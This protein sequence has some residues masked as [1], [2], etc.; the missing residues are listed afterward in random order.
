MCV[1]NQEKMFLDAYTSTIM[2]DNYHVEY[3]IAALA[4]SRACLKPPKP[5]VLKVYE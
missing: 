3:V 4:S 2:K 5:R 1:Q